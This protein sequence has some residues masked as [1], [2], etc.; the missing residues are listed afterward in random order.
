MIT[1]FGGYIV[2]C[3]HAICDGITFCRAV[4]SI[5]RSKVIA[6]PRKKLRALRRCYRLLLETARSTT[7]TCR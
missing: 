3:Q 5:L 6:K 2:Q 1:E 4:L 7:H